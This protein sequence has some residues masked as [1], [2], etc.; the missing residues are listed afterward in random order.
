MAVMFL[1]SL[2]SLD[3]GNQDTGV[4]GRH[5]KIGQVLNQIRNKGKDRHSENYEIQ[6]GE[7]MK[8]RVLTEPPP[9]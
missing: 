4:R 8:V 5:E 3:T 2:D 6:V 9:Y 1:C 7:D